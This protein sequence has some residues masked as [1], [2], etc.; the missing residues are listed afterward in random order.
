MEATEGDIT[1]AAG[2]EE[3][4]DS[5]TLTVSFTH[6]ITNAEGQL[7]TVELASESFAIGSVVFRGETDKPFP[8]KISADIGG[9]EPLTTW[10]V[11]FPGDEVKFVLVDYF[12]SYPAVQ[13]AL[14]E[15]SQMSEDHAKKFSISVDFSAL[16]EELDLG[17]VEVFSTQFDDERERQFVD[18]ATVLL[19]D[20]KF[21]IEADINKPAVVSVL[22][23]SAGSD[24]FA[25][26]S[27]EFSNSDDSLPSSSDSLGDRSIATP[28]SKSP[29]LA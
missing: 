16:D 2:S 1:S 11:L 8:I 15:R 3:R 12:K 17:V 13:L 26:C 9:D 18:L 27:I 5:S 21:L 6:E 14:V 4:L 23:R 24:H 29:V 20:A 22:I 28:S 7:E 10:A 19:E 25:S